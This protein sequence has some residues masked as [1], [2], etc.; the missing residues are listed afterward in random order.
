MNAMHCLGVD[1]G[2]TAVKIGLFSMDGQL[3]CKLQNPVNKAA[4]PEGILSEIAAS[5][6][7]LMN[8]QHAEDVCCL[9][10]GVP[11]NVAEGRFAL[12]CVN[13]SWRNVPVSD[14]LEK[15]LHMPVTILHDASAAALGEHWRGASRAYDSSVLVTLGTGV[16]GGLIDR[17]RLVE[18][19]H[20]CDGELGHMTLFPDEASPFPCS[21]GKRG[22]L[23]Q[24]T[25]AP[26]IVRQARAALAASDT[27]SLLRSV[28]D[29]QA[30]DVFDA[31]KAGDALALGVVDRVCFY[32]GVALANVAAVF[33][34]EAF[35]I[36]GGVSKAGRILTDTI[37]PYYRQYAY[38]GTDHAEFVLAKLGNEAGMYGAARFALDKLGSL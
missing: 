9:G 25:A 16:G 34:P 4:G 31:A 13:L 32:L 6:A 10:M 35:I 2:G 3:I 33:D 19:A 14:F 17:N 29:L 27:P 1:L 20:G 38:P 8:E 28:A 18:G 37:L 30:K 23:E 5:A 21:C 7:R 15:L 24:Y 36:G 26:A 22:C 11:G 12:R